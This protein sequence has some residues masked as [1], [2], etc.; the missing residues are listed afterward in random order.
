MR[1]FFYLILMVF[2]SCGQKTSTIINDSAWKDSLIAENEN[3]KRE[4]DSLESMLGND[5]FI[6]GIIKAKD[7]FL[8]GDTA[9]FDFCTVYKR[10]GIADYFHYAVVDYDPFA[11]EER[12][13]QEQL[14]LID[15]KDSIPINSTFPNRINIVNYKRGTNYLVGYFIMTWHGKHPSRLHCST[16]FVVK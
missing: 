5:C 3:L 10:K 15:Y 9:K 16:P 1:P 8:F 14:D 4:R 2:I 11:G 13:H 7:E 6:G 12:N